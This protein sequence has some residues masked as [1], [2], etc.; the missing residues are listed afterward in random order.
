MADTLIP[1][2]ATSIFDE[3]LIV[4]EG[5]FMNITAIAKNSNATTNPINV[6]TRSFG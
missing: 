6:N 5:L 1:I 4:I 2:T 3:R